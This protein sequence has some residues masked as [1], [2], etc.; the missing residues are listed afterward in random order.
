MRWIIALLLFVLGIGF[1]DASTRQLLTGTASFRLAQSIGTNGN[2]LFVYFPGI[3]A[4]G[5]SSI[6]D[7]LPTLREHG[8]VMMVSYNGMRFEAD[9][10]VEQTVARLSD[11]V[12]RVGYDKVVLI[13][14]SM[15][16]LV[17]Y[18]TYRQIKQ[19]DLAV[20]YSM[21]L[22]DAP[23]GRGDL[24]SPLNII[25]L[26]SLGWWAGPISNLFSK[27]YFN[28]TFVE[29]KG[30]NIED[31]VDRKRLARQVE[32]SKSFPLSWAMDQN[33]F[34]L[35]HG[36]P[37]PDSLK[38]ARVI[39]VR[40]MRDDDTVRPEAFDPWNDASGGKAVRLEVDSTHVGYAERPFTWNRALRS[41]ILPALQ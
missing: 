7:Q 17:A 10:I 31:G 39:Y 20:S 32:E 2:T 21:I 35:R 22:I 36:A 25:S 23:T 27:T 1:L 18:D 28:A 29:P 37:A 6:K 40:S 15:G 3:L 24:Q 9:V 41:K 11:D 8:D 38:D 30:V 12:Q 14:S 16:G 19:E 33:R 34:I 13:G 26:G 4:S 5:E